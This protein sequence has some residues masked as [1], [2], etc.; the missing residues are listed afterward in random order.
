MLVSDLRRD[1][2]RTHFARLAEAPFATFERLFAEMRDRGLAEIKAAKPDIGEIVLTYAADMR[3]VGQE[4]AV[5]VPLSAGLFAAHDSAAIKRAFDAVHVQRYGYA[6]PDEPAEIVSLRLSAIGII[7]KPALAEI[8]QA[9]GA[10][11]EA[12][13]IA[14]RPVHFGVL[15]GRIDTPLYRRD[16]LAA[17]HAIT[18]PALIQEYASTTVLA[19]GD[20]L[21]VDRFG[22]LD[23]A[24]GG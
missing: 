18:G 22:N 2:V 6:S 16:G 12:A 9:D 11:P 4:H 21:V 23:I 19:P 15:G 1:F 8:A 14:R 17:G 3:Y 7:G 24:L 10:L 13:L 20:R 5:I